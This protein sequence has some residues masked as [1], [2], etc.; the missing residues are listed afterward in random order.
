MS[1][2]L[3][4]N[5]AVLSGMMPGWIPATVTVR[6]T[7]GVATSA[8]AASATPATATPA[9]AAASRVRAACPGASAAASIRLAA[10]STP[11]TSQT[12]PSAA[13]ESRRRSFHWLVPST[14][15]VP[16]RS[17]HDRTYS[18]ATQAA[19][20]TIRAAAIRPGRGSRSAHH[21]KPP[22]GSQVTASTAANTSRPGPTLGTSQ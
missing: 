5:R 6:V 15:Q 19:G 2:W 21:A 1:R 8:P 17:C 13:T 11:L 9:T 7:A 12:P 20:T 14:A 18:P 22:A 4:A 3:A 16:P 10:T